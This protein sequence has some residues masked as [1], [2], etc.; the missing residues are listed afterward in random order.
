MNLFYYCINIAMLLLAM[1]KTAIS[2]LVI[3]DLA[4]QWLRQWFIKCF[5]M[6]LFMALKNISTFPYFYRKKDQCTYSSL[7]V[8]VQ[9]HAKYLKFSKCKQ[10]H[11]HSLGEPRWAWVPTQEE[12]IQPQQII[13]MC[14]GAKKLCN[15]YWRLYYSLWLNYWLPHDITT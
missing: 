3:C 1:Y 6:F 15:Q 5:R 14:L 4:D 8:D 11:T 9:G 2:R 12:R 10:T 13:L 7:Q